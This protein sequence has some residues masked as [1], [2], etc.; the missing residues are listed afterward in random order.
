MAIELVFGQ[1]V[2]THPLT[3]LLGLLVSGVILLK[4][5]GELWRM[6][7][8]RRS[9]P[10]ASTMSRSALDVVSPVFGYRLAYGKQVKIAGVPENSAQTTD[11][12]GASEG[13]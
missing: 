1:A 4:E 7:S 3:A 6:G 2:I 8:P 10:E 9:E 5:A 11:P 13:S 12:T